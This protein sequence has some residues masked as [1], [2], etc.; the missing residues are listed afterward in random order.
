MAKK[1]IIFIF[2]LILV[3]SNVFA[4]DGDYDYNDAKS[5]QNNDFF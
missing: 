5:Y 3:I 2:V 4:Q 1:L